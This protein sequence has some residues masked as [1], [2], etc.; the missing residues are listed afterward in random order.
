VAGKAITA[1]MRELDYEDGAVR[2]ALSRACSS[3]FLER[4]RNGRETGYRLS[5]EDAALLSSVQ[6]MVAEFGNRTEWN[7]EWTVVLF[8]VPDELRHLRAGLNTRLGFLGFGRLQDGAWC[9]TRNV[10][11]QLKEVLAPLREHC[12]V[13]VF[14]GRPW[15]GADIDE[16]MTTC[17]DLDRLTRGYDKLVADFRPLRG[18]RNERGLTALRSWIRLTHDY[19]NLVNHD[20]ELPAALLPP[21][22]RRARADAVALFASLERTLRPVAEQHVRRTLGLA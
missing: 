20:P 8:T 14:V 6:T 4:Q 12:A 9:S 5:L 16:L 17:W 1:L 15:L 11:P 22:A 19:R 21:P 7:G 3:G 13:H 10:E 2:V 18:R